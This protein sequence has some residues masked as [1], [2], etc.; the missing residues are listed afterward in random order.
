MTQQAPTG[1][2]TPGPVVYPGSQSAG[3]PP[4]LPSPNS[5]NVYQQIEGSANYYEPAIYEL[6]TF[7]SGLVNQSDE[8][9][10]QFIPISDVSPTNPTQTLIFAVGVLPPS[11]NV[12]ARILDRS[13]VIQE[14]P[15]VPSGPPANL[16]T[17]VAAR[18]QV[19]A[20][21][22]PTDG[23]VGA[24]MQGPKYTKFSV[25]QLGNIFAQAYLDR[26]GRD[27]T[28]DEL[29]IYVGQTIREN[30]G[31]WPNNNPGFIG[32]YFPTAGTVDERGVDTGLK[33][34]AIPAG[35]PV[36]RVYNPGTVGVNV[37]STQGAIEYY[38]SYPSPVQGAN[39]YFQTIENTGG[40]TNGVP[41]AIAFAQQG[42]LNGFLTQI[43]SIPG[44]PYFTDTL[45][46]YEGNFPNVKAIA[47]QLSAAGLGTPPLTSTVMSDGSQPANAWKTKGSANASQASQN[48]ALTA[49]TNLNATNLGQSYQQ[50]Q[51]NMINATLA[52]IQQMKNTP[53]LKMLVNPTS[54]KLGAEKIISDGERSRN[55]PIVEQWGDAL[56]KI[57]ASGKVAAFYSI[58]ATMTSGGPGLTRTARQYSLAYQNFLSLWLLY[59]NNG[60]IW[61]NPTQFAPP[62]SSSSGVSTPNATTVTSQPSNLSVLGSIYIFYDNIL[63]LG[64]FDSFNLTESETTPFSLEYNFNFTVR[65]T[66]LLDNTDDL[67]LQISG[68]QQ[69]QTNLMSGLP[70][71]N[72]IGMTPGALALQSM[73]AQPAGKVNPP[74]GLTSQQYAQLGQANPG[75]SS[76]S[77]NS[78]GV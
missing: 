16:T 7:Y 18:T 40:V 46:N 12:T 23:T 13:A 76:G 39:G 49:N 52:A 6:L 14:T 35:Q 1:Y 2:I 37:N 30:S 54:F 55:G 24:N 29:A 25:V 62:S 48:T 69:S 21:Q 5:S 11:S 10:G 67:S 31:N 43:T 74:P 60:G 77:F 15:P 44:K 56:D 33:R 53:P 20:Y 68:L 42:N 3:P 58:D 47:A 32:N 4:N 34:S 28:T 72:Q 65:A 50:A 71:P 19:T 26:Y 75:V 22:I 59:K 17:N 73:N 63:Y 38:N 66:F 36:F 57:E 61:F 70:N 41:N 8:L 78:K 45:S 9:D 51:Q 64:S 27:P